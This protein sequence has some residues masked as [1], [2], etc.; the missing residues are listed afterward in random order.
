V[1]QSKHLSTLI[2]AAVA[3]WAVFLFIGGIAAS[4]KLLGPFSSVTGALG[5]LLLAFDRWLWRIP[6]LHPWFVDVPDIRG[7]W[8]AEIRSNWINPATGVQI[9]PI[10]GFMV[11]R[12]IYSTL[13]MRLITKESA[14]KLLA[15]RILRDADGLYTVTGI[16]SNEPKHSLRERSPIHYGSL[17]LR[18]SGEPVTNLDG[19]YWTDRKTQGELV[20]SE[21]K[22]KYA[23][24]FESASTMFPT[25]V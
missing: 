14:S 22:I 5:L 6:L 12:Q 15:A 7:V 23:D 2:A 9:S 8:K 3:L 24:D 25:I 18:V 13:S 21:R 10:A 11:I 17:V 1:I 19:H 20:L 16:Y 4:P